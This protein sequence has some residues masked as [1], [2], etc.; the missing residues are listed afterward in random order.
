MRLILVTYMMG[1]T[2]TFASDTQE[3]FFNWLAHRQNFPLPHDPYTSPRMANRQLK[4]LFSILHRELLT[5]LLNK[6]QQIL[7]SSNV[8]G[9]WIPAFLCLLGLA[10]AQEDMQR[11]IYI[12]MDDR[13]R[14]G[15]VVGAQAANEADGAAGAIDEKFHFLC[16]LFFSKFNK[17]LNPLKDREYEHMTKWVG[18]RGM[19]FVRAV[20]DLIDE[21]S[22]FPFLFYPSFYS[23]LF[24]GKRPQYSMN[25]ALHY[26]RWKPS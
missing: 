18:E 26:N 2:L 10:V 11:T 20:A 22:K 7:H 13:W 1:H 24:H 8:R 14:R 15:E 9:N 4:Y 16:S 17:S 19:R 12:I 25:I 3:S 21:K 23:I 5:N 6:L